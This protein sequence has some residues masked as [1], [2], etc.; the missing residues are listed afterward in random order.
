MAECEAGQGQ[1]PL[2]CGAACS[3]ALGPGV[4][5]G[6][7]VQTASPPG[8][9]G[10]GSVC[11]APHAHSPL[12]PPWWAPPQCRLLPGGWQAVF[13]HFQRTRKQF[14][15]LGN[16]SLRTR[17]CHS[18]IRATP[19]GSS[20]WVLGVLARP[21]SFQAASRNAQADALQKNDKSTEEPAEPS[22]ALQARATP[23]LAEWLGHTCG[24]LVERCS[25]WLGVSLCLQPK[26]LRSVVVERAATQMGRQAHTPSVSIM[27]I[28][29]FI[30]ML[31]NIVFIYHRATSFSGQ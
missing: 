15:F 4:L 23:L 9:R 26:P 13:P 31:M 29:S 16:L 22:R 2:P 17:K 21:Q 14:D 25:T 28:S 11:A 10:H 8:S 18:G 1:V 7:Q 30:K 19:R 24:W 20:W 12:C 6:P 5:P 3:C 27:L